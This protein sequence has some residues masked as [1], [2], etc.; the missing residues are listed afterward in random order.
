MFFFKK[1][2]KKD[3]FS[4]EYDNPKKQDNYDFVLPLVKQNGAVLEFA[5]DKLKNNFELVLTAV[6]NTPL[7]ILFASEQLKTNPTIFRCAYKNGFNIFI[8]DDYVDYLNSV[9]DN[10][11]AEWISLLIHCKELVETLVHEPNQ[12]QFNIPIS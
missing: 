10:Q 9:G 8:N 1:K 5:S 12:C 4:L 11:N 2:I 3:P 6:Q 7:A